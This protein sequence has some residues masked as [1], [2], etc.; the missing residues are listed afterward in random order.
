LL[1]NGTVNTFPR[2]RIKLATT[3]EG[4][5][6]V[7]ASKFSR[8]L[9]LQLVFWAVTPCSLIDVS[10]GPVASIIRVKEQS[11]YILKVKAAVSSYMLVLS[12][13]LHGVTSQNTAIIQI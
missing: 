7:K 4:I 2:Q 6:N 13:N 3:E 11:S 1:G 9:I 5:D 12:T 8:R 10:E